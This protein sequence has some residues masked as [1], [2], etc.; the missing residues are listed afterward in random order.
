M[1]TLYKSISSGE[2]EEVIKKENPVIIDIRTPMEFASGNISGAKNIDFYSSDFSE[3]LK[4]LSKDKTY[5][6]Y[7]RSG[8]RSKV[9]LGMMKELGFQRVYELGGG[10]I[11]L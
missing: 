1:E 9:A 8:S 4:A 11:S 7:C 3:S 2:F 5:L 10:I 6:I